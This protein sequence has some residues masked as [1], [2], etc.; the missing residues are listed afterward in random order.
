MLGYPAI[1]VTDIGTVAGVVRAWEA[2]KATGVRFIAGACIVTSCGGQ[3]L[4]YPTDPPAWSR[5]TRLLMIGKRRAGKGGCLL[6]WHD[7]APWSDGM[8]AILVPQEPD[9]TNVAALTDLKAVYGKR[10]YMALSQRRRPDD[11]VRIDVLAR[12]AGSA[13]IRAVV[14]GDVLYHAP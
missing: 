3:L 13:G 1:G 6:H 4:L 14:T 2:Q 8:I 7:L 5:L 12:Q 10:G 9:D 11:A